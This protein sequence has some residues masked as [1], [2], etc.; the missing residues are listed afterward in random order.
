MLTMDVRQMDGQGGPP[1]YKLDQRPWLMGANMC[2]MVDL[3]MDITI[4]DSEV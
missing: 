4:S 2:S 3:R 1:S